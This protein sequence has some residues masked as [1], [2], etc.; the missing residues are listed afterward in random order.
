MLSTYYYYTLNIKSNGLSE[1]AKMFLRISSMNQSR[2]PSATQT[3]E[4]SRNTVSMVFQVI[5][6][7]V[8]CSCLRGSVAGSSLSPLHVNRWRLY[9]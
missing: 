1:T 7:C 5:E 6:I 9:Y 8:I 2:L 3:K 4:H